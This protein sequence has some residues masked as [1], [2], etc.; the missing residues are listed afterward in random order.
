MP[1]CSPYFLRVGV[2]SKNAVDLAR[3][4]LTQFGSLNGILASP[5]S[6]LTQAHGIGSRKYVQLRAIF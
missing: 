4:L 2:T 3:D 1:N 6:E 5:L